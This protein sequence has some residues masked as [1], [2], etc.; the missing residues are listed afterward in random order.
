MSAVSYCHSKNIIHRDL[1]PNNIL[2]LDKEEHSQIKLIDFGT[3]KLVKTNEKL[4][5]FIGTPYFIAPEILKQ[6]KGQGYSSKC[7]IWS[8][9]VMLYILL[10]G[11]P[12]F[13]GENEE[14]LYEK[15]L[16]GKYNF[17]GDE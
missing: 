16:A 10:S 8:C 9:G 15:I 4:F 5:E 11:Y 17:N 2:F 3:S 1:K 13:N 7:D 12:P 14:E 6:K